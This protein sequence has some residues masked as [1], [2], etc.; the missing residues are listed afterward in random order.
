MHNH[1]DQDHAVDLLK[2]SSGQCRSRRSFLQ[3]L[4]YV[5]GAVAA[6][7]VGAPFARYLFGIPTQEVHWVDLGSAKDFPL[8]ETRRVTFDNPLRTPWDGVTAMTE[9]FVRYEGK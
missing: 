6:V 4:T 7:L 5:L 9:V 2:P 3:W 1:P 8:Q